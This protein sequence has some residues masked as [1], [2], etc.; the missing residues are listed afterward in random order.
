MRPIEHTQSGARV[1]PAR[2]TSTGTRRRHQLITAAIEVLA[3]EGYDSASTV[4]IARH[5]GVSRG[6]LTYHFRNRADLID[7]VVTAVYDVARGVVQPAVAGAAT[8]RD[9][10]LAFVDGSIAFY[11]DYPQHMAALREI[12][13]QRTDEHTIREE[14][15]EHDA[16]TAAIEEILRQGQRRGQ[17]RPFDVAV[18]T[19]TIRGALDAAISGATTGQASLLRAEL[20]ETIDRATRAPETCAT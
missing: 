3:G 8:P 19:R 9:S 18:M 7:G 16:E 13:R 15:P 10:L 17:F 12:Y 5:A 6:V 2:P 1:A 20:R 4:R 11:S 14:R